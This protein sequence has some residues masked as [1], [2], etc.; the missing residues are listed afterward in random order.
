MIYSEA[1]YFDG[2]PVAHI[3]EWQEH[4]RLLRLGRRSMAQIKQR[5][6]TPALRLVR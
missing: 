3:A 2:I 5:P 4:N 6:R 1:A